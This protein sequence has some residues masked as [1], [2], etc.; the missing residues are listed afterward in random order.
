[1][2]VS[3]AVR[4][5]RA[6]VGGKYNRLKVLLFDPGR[7]YDEKPRTD[8]IWNEVFVLLFVGLAGFAGTFYVTQQIMSHFVT[9]GV[10]QGPEQFLIS[11]DKAI[12]IWAY[13]ARAVVGIYVLWVGFSLAYYAL[14]WLY[15]DQGSFF[16]TAQY[17]AWTLVP[18]FFYNIVKTIAMVYLAVTSEVIDPQDLDING[19]VTTAPAEDATAFLFRQVFEEPAI[20]GAMAIGIVFVLWSGYIAS[21]AVSELRDIP[22]GDA[23]KAVAAP[24]VVYVLWLINEILG[25]AGV[26]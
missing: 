9:S 12:Q 4:N 21:Y 26:L 1:M 8:R 11:G 13:G 14:S 20:L 25:Y 18:L 6:F 3:A 24:V 22:L 7:F 10:D 16:Q 17:T 15:S 23:R 19:Q 5:P 2:S